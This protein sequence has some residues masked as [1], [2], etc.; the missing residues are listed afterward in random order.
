MP[1]SFLGAG[2]RKSNAGSAAVA[3]GYP[4]GLANGDLLIGVVGGKNNDTHTWPSPWVKQGQQN[5]GA[6]W[7]TSW[8][9]LVYSGV[10]AAPNVTWTGSVSNFGQVVALR[11]AHPTAFEGNVTVSGSTG[12]PHA[13]AGVALSSKD[14]IVA[15][16]GGGAA[17]TAYGAVSGWSEDLDNGSATGATRNVFGTR[18]YSNSSGST[19]D[20]INPTGGTAGWA[21]WA[22]EIVADRYVGSLSTTLGGA[23]L[24][25]TGTCAFAPLTGTLSSSL[26]AATLTATGNVSSSGL[27]SITLSSSTLSATGSVSV[28]GTLSTT[29][30]DSTLTAVGAYGDSAT[31]NLSVS[32]DSVSLE[33]G[34]NTTSF[35]TAAI[36]LG[37]ATLAAIGGAQATGSASIDIS[38]VALA[39]VARVEAI[40]QLSVSLG[41]VTT[42][43]VGAA[44]ATGSLVVTMENVTL[45]G[46]DSSATP[47]AGRD[48]GHSWGLN[49]RSSNRRIGGLALR[50][51]A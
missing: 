11:G 45:A 48:D 12:S 25:A 47:T 18:T 17:N 44:L 28:A 27:A 35:G 23:T 20:I 8:A 37:D 43:A 40:G 22:Q 10:S 3:P 16:F 9:T 31:G 6:S 42:Q 14:V 50:R 26:G 5:G 21:L 36:S 15:Y 49:R 33:A 32:L 7:T 2:T 51:A 4:A 39:G 13:I 19:T 38:S 34:A 1:V 24:A 46:G 41:D 30:Q 29:L